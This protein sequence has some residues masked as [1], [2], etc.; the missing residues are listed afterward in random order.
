MST[1]TKV[2][3][4]L[5]TLFALFACGAVLVFVGSTNNY[6]ALTDKG[7]EV[8]GVSADSE[9]SHQKFIEKFDLPFNLISDTE[10]TLFQSPEREKSS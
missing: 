7:F 8:I 5:L 6:K 3:I 4:V 10:K 1:L 9:K 2:L